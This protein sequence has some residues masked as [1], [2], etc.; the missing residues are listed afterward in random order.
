MCVGGACIK[1][2]ITRL[3]YSLQYSPIDSSLSNIYFTIFI[4]SYLTGYLLDYVVCTGTVS[5]IV[6]A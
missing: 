2:F 1:W 4:G 5:T 6:C 3:I